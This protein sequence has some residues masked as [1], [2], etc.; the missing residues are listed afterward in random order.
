MK[1]TF[2]YKGGPGSGDFGHEGRPG[3]VGG[4]G[5]GNRPVPEDAVIFTGNLYHNTT[6]DHL[7]SILSKG[8]TVPPTS[9]IKDAVY[10]FR[11]SANNYGSNFGGVKVSVHVENI[12]LA[13]RAGP[14]MDIAAAIRNDIDEKAHSAK[15]TLE[16]DKFR[17]LRNDDNYVNELARKKF[18]ALGYDGYEQGFDAIAITNL[19]LLKKVT[20]VN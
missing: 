5:E 16:R 19:S 2:V 8:L 3:L 9:K 6:E 17:D 11:E 7:D 13:P 18:T 20:R 15:T 14:L 4:S 12:R 1:L 10:F